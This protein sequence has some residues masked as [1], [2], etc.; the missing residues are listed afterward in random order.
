MTHLV[1]V[2]HLFEE[3]EFWVLVAV[4]ILVVLVWKPVKRAVVGGLDARATR[5][6]DEL[7][8]ASALR[9]EAERALA[10]Y[11]QKEREAAAE[12]EAIIAHAR[13]EAQRI[14]AQSAHDLDQLLRRRQQLAEERIAQEEARALAEIRSLAVDIAIAAARRVIAA[15]LD[16]QRGAALI[17]GAIAALPHQLQ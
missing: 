11:Q 2:M 10:G 12:A 8:A 6:R 3:P 14:A 15:E 1:A 9:E 7:A 4:I 13:A 5:I 17:D 16:Q